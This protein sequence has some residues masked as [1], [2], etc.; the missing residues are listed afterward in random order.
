MNTETLSALPTSAKAMLEPIQK[1]NQQAVATFEQLAA[2]QLDSLRAYSE[3][4]LGQLKA[5]I[6]VKDL[7]GL[8]DLVSKQKDALRAVGERLWED[9]SA[10]AKM[11]VE[12]VAEAQRAGVQAPRT[13]P[14]KMTAA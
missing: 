3:L 11:G 14:A 13:A 7:E 5:A 8:R 12:F 1:V 9:T 2:H 10:V 6:E 4:G